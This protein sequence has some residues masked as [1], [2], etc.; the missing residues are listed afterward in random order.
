MTLLTSLRIEI[1]SRNLWSLADLFPIDVSILS[2][3][4]LSRSLVLS[5]HHYTQLIIPFN[6]SLKQRD[7]L[8]A[9]SSQSQ[10]LDSGATPSPSPKALWGNGKIS[11]CSPNAFTRTFNFNYWNCQAQLWKLK[12]LLSAW[13]QFCILSYSS[14]NA[15]VRMWVPSPFPSAPTP[16]TPQPNENWFFPTVDSVDLQ[17]MQI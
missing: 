11:N 9:S 5:H 13:M 8:K 7:M 10:C 15:F 17:S 14:S 4:T 3:A 12:M 6:N 16:R 1:K 2:H